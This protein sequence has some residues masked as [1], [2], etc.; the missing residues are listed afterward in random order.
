MSPQPLE[1]SNEVGSDIFTQRH[2]F[3]REQTQFM[4]KLSRLGMKL[5]GQTK[6]QLVLSSEQAHWP[7]GREGGFSPVHCGANMLGLVGTGAVG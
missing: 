6:T 2:W 4:L 7:R 1:K 3:V 5:F